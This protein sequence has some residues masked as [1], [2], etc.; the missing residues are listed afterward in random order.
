[1]HSA[2]DSK[3]AY[4]IYLT[5]FGRGGY[6]SIYPAYQGDVNGTKERIHRKLVTLGSL[7]MKTVQGTLGPWVESLR[8]T[9]LKMAKLGLWI[10]KRP[11]EPFGD[12]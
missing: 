9:P 10:L 4:E 12:R 7:S 3:L 8:H 2:K 1:M 5:A 6:M 11:E